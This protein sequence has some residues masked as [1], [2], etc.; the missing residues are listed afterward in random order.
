MCSKTVMYMENWPFCYRLHQGAASLT[1][2]SHKINPK[3]GLQILDLI[4]LAR[5]SGCE[6]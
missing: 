1:V 5:L 2:N 4:S 3:V 6:R